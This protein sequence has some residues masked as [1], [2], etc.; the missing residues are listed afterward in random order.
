VKEAEVKKKV[1]HVF[2]ELLYLQ[3][4]Q[5]LLQHSDSI[6]SN[7]LEKAQLRFKT[8]ESNILEKTT[9]ETQRG[10]MLQQLK[11]LQHDYSIVQLQL[12]LLL[13]TTS[14][15]VPVAENFKLNL[16]VFPDTSIVQHPFIKQLQQQQQVSL[17]KIKFEKSKLLPDLFAAYNNQTI[18]GVG[19]DEK[20]YSSSKRFQSVQ[21]GVGIPLF[22]G[23][24]KSNINA[25]KVNYQMAQNNYLAGLQ[26]LQTQYAQVMEQYNKN[27]Q[28]V[29]YYETTALKNADTI[30][31]TA[32]KQFLNGDINYLDWVLLT[33]QS[34]AIQS[35]YLDAIKNFNSS[36]I[37][38]N[39]FINQ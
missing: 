28:A 39:S 8:G 37:E 33:N 17:A 14:D 12:K 15:Y 38:I 13:N 27:Q 23:A 5:K 4:K 25:M 2:Y 36:I 20:K 24:Q 22:S 7:F 26:T 18:Q 35:E 16:V 34:I 29:N 32:D 1:A 6:Y 30:I 10:Q 3:Q 31:Q 21:I 9:A 11:Q 19:A